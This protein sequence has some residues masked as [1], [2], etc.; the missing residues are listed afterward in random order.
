MQAFNNTA[1]TAGSKTTRI[2]KA[3]IKSVTT[4]IMPKKALQKQ[5]RYTQRLLKKPL[6]MKVKDFVER[7]MMMNKLLTC[8]PNA[9]PTVPASKI[10]DN[11]ILDLLESEM[12]ISW[13]RHM[14]LQG[15][16]PM[17]GTIVG[18]VDFCKRIQLTKELPVVKKSSHNKTR[19]SHNNSNKKES[20]NRNP[21]GEVQVLTTVCCTDQTRPITQRTATPSRIL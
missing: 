20:K 15:F 13:K 8:F 6:D 16:D 14:V 7:I 12:P 17:D 1:R 11:N 2:H 19:K 9:S 18:L 3:A 5:K 21:K 4:H 10:P